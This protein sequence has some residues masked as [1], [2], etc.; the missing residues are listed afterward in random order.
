VYRSLPDLELVTESSLLSILRWNYKVNMD[1]TMCSDD[2]GQIVLVKYCPKTFK[3]VRN[4]ISLSACTFWCSKGLSY[5][6]T[7]QANGSELAFISLLTSEKE[8]RYV[9]YSVMKS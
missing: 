4:S 5:F 1:K 8:F 7:L 2:N 9:C 3:F 6:V